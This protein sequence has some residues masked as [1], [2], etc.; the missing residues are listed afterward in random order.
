VAEARLVPIAQAL[1]AAL[2]FGASTPA[3]KWLLGDVAPA[4]LAGWLY[5][6]AALGTAGTWVGAEPRRDRAFAGASRRRLAAAVI[7]GGIVAPVLL[8]E[9]LARA[10]AGSVALLLNLELVF[11]AVVGAWWFRDALGPRGWAGVAVAVI[12]G[13]IV[14]AGE[15]WP[16]VAAAG[17]VA[18]A[19]LCW[20]L[21]NHWTA[22]ID[23]L[24]PARATFWKG[25]VAGTTNLGIAALLGVAA[26]APSR[27]ALAL[28][29]GALAYGASVTLYIRAAQQ[30]GATRAQVLFATAPFAGAALAWVVLG[31]PLSAA[32]VGG[33]VLLAGSIALLLGAR[34]EHDHHHEEIEHVHAHRHDDGHHDHVHPPGERPASHA[35]WHRHEARTHA[36]PHWPDLHHRHAHPRGKGP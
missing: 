8:L 36:H 29:V 34:H 20:A 26:I 28:A 30:L 22:R 21:D 7:A 18:A 3:S 31:E 23:G 14:G 12:A 25:A 17:L 2:L 10:Q 16:G 35:H 11:T 13:V 19:C 1:V 33:A 32:Q 15:G 9:G 4:A 27:A 6:G 24:S 5:L